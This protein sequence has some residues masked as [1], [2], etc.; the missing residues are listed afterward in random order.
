MNSDDEELRLNDKLPC[1]LLALCDEDDTMYIYKTLHQA[2]ALT[3]I[4]I[5]H[6]ENIGNTHVKQRTR[7]QQRLEQEEPVAKCY[8]KKRVMHKER[9][10]YNCQKRQLYG[11]SMNKRRR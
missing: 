1:N 5:A 3:I 11:L 4:A 2:I 7:R 10:R 6:V 9:R 8:N